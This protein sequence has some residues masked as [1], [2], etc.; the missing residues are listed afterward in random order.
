MKTTSKLLFLAFLLIGF[1][2]AN[3][4]IDRDAL[5]PLKDIVHL[6]DVIIDGSICVGLDC[7][8]GENFGF[9][10]QRLKENNLRIHFDDTSVSASFPNNDWRIV[11]NDSNNG[12]LN[13][14][15]VEDAT[16]GR[17]GRHQPDR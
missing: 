3:A 4:Q 16:A 12:G 8:N 10:T 6:D 7:V 9:D 13:H 1:G 2:E 14:F 15:T 5:S 11:I 17:H